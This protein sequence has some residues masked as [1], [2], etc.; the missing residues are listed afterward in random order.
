MDSGQNKRLQYFRGWAEKPD[1]KFLRWCPCPVC[2]DQCRLPY[3]RNLTSRDSE[4]EE[5][6]DAFDGSRSEMLQVE[7]ADFVLAKGL[8]IPTALDCSPH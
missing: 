6:G 2:D 8:T 4:V 3:R 1:T 7:D 5:V